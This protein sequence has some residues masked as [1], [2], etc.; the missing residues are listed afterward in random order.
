MQGRAHW[1]IS[2]EM[3]VRIQSRPILLIRMLLRLLEMGGTRNEGV[4][5]KIGKKNK[6]LLK[7]SKEERNLDKFNTRRKNRSPN[8]YR[9]IEKHA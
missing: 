9:E 1:I 3:E 6:F 7:K 8:L 5:S 2:R 4:L